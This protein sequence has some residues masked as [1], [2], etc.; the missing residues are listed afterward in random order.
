MG[1][2]LVERACILSDK[3]RRNKVLAAR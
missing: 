2:R 1:A 3:P